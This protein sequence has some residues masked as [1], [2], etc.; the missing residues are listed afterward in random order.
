MCFHSFLVELQ[1]QLVRLMPG[2]CLLCK[3]PTVC[4]T[5]YCMACVHAL[6]RNIL[7]C[8]FCAL[9][10]DVHGQTRCAR[11]L[12]HPRFQCATVPLLY[13]GNVPALI[14]AFKFHA[15]LPAA[16]LLAGLLDKSLPVLDGAY[17]LTVPQ[18]P[19]RA[20]QR[21]FDHIEWLASLCQTIRHFPRITAYR[22]YD[23]PPLRQLNRRQRLKLMKD[24]FAIK[25]N[26]SGKHIVLLDDVMTTG[27]TLHALATQCQQLGARRVEAVALARTPPSAWLDLH[28]PYNPH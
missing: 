2:H 26:V 14:H 17:L 21:G 28:A 24:A 6:P 18:H 7:S 25:S 11:C 27:A 15:A 23:T 1:R 12:R 19:H 3:C 16:T 4:L 10:L 9:P 20:R 5:G 13:S 8:H 22:C